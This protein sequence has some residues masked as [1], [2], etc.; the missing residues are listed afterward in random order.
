MRAGTETNTERDKWGCDGMWCEGCICKANKQHVWQVCCHTATRRHK[1]PPE[2]AQCHTCPHC[3]GC[4]SPN[5]AA[6][7]DCSKKYWV[8]YPVFGSFTVLSFCLQ[9]VAS[10]LSCSRFQ[11]NLLWSLS[12]HNSQKILSSQG[13]RDVRQRHRVRWKG[14]VCADVLKMIKS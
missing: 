1:P 13:R 5:L 4:C 2:H 7:E 9:K 3:R 8:I 11:L 12:H 10:S 14:Q 6:F